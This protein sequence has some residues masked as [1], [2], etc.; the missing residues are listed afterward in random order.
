[1][2]DQPGLVA[3]LRNTPA[4]KSAF[5]TRIDAVFHSNTANTRAIPS[6]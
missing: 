2:I 3:A 6:D 1:L 4:L 5:D